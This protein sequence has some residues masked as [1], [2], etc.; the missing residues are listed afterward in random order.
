MSDPRLMAINEKLN[1][2]VAMIR[3]ENPN[4]AERDVLE[5]AASM[6]LTEQKTF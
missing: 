2:Y 1:K 6:A 4:M 5:R 3:L